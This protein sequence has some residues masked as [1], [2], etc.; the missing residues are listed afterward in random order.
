[1]DSFFTGKKFNLFKLKNS[2]YKIILIAINICIIFVFGGNE[3][4]KNNIIGGRE[5]G[6]CFYIHNI[7][8]NI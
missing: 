1:M 6:G 3:L 2:L 4:T 5:E 8:V 7:T